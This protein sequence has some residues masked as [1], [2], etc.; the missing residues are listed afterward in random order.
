L[1]NVPIGPGPS[2]ISFWPSFQRGSNVANFGDVRFKG[3]KRIGNETA[4][5]AAGLANGLNSTLSVGLYVRSPESLGIHEQY[6][7]HF[8]AGTL[9]GSSAPVLPGASGGPGPATSLAATGRAELSIVTAAETKLEAQ[10]TTMVLAKGS[11]PMKAQR[12][13]QNRQQAGNQYQKLKTQRPGY[14]S[15]QV[16]QVWESAKSPDGLVYDPWDNEQLLWDRSKPRTGQWDMGH[17]PGHEYKNLVNRLIKG[18]IT[19]KQFLSEYRNPANY[20]PESVKNNRSHKFEKK[21]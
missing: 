19:L 7:S 6:A 1:G 20:Q 18:E 4:A 10:A 5:S 17:K 3:W 12:D 15:D 16:E 2:F 14:A 13:E 9:V 11:P 8:Y 21:D